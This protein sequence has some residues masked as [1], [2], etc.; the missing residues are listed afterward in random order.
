MIL[1]YQNGLSI[2]QVRPGLQSAGR[3]MGFLHLA[4]IL[5]AKPELPILI[6]VVLS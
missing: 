4:L 5:L 2:L 3:I 6:R 1:K